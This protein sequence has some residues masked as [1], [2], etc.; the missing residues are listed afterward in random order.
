VYLGEQLFCRFEMT[1]DADVY[2]RLLG[3]HIGD[4]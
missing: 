3:C 1:V 4:Q 2:G